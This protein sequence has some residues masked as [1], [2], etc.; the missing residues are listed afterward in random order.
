[1]EQPSQTL[2]PPQLPPL[3]WIEQQQRTEIEVSTP[4]SPSEGHRPATLQRHSSRSS[5]Q[6]ASLG[7]DIHEDDGALDTIYASVLTDLHNLCEKTKMALEHTANDSFISQKQK[8]TYHSLENL[9]VTFRIW[10][11]E[12]LEDHQTLLDGLRHLAS[13]NAELNSKLRRA[14]LALRRLF[15]SMDQNLEDSKPDSRFVVFLPPPLPPAITIWTDQKTPTN[16]HLNSGEF[17]SSSA[18]WMI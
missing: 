14:L 4:T 9:R 12:I 3:S 7:D 16:F 11:S 2:Q 15:N 1:M 5:L 18:N 17:T 13:L 10:A 6:P 8:E